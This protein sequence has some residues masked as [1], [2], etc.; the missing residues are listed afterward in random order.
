[1]EQKFVKWPKTVEDIYST[2]PAFKWFEVSPAEIRDKYYPDLAT[3]AA[4]IKVV[5][6]ELMLNNMNYD[7]WNATTKYKKIREI[8]PK[9]P[10]INFEDYYN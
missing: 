3:C 5:D 8:D 4:R 6:T 9:I 10:E 7:F 1:M 2:W